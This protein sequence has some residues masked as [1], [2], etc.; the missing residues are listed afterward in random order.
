[1]FFIIL[2]P[3][4]DFISIKW[5]TNSLF[6]DSIYVSHRLIFY[7]SISLLIF[8]WL[9]W[10]WSFLF[11]WNDVWID[12]PFM[13]LITMGLIF[14]FSS[15][16]NRIWHHPDMKNHFLMSSF[17]KIFWHNMNFNMPEWFLF[18]F[19]TNR[20][21]WWPSI[22]IIIIHH[23]IDCYLFII[24]HIILWCHLEKFFIKLFENHW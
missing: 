13:E 4:N 9:H 11:S 5:E 2:L 6:S 22:M 8:F 3:Y 15:F 12:F 23:Q 21:L 14:I 7:E 10:I 1:M 16:Q 20:L 18:I 24:K 19:M 17:F